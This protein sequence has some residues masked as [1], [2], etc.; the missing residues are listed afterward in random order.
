M[1]ADTI[2][3]FGLLDVSLNNN[4]AVTLIRQS[5]ID[6]STTRDNPFVC[7]QGTSTTNRCNQRERRSFEIIQVDQKQC[8]WRGQDV[9]W[10]L[11]RNLE[12][13]VIWLWSASTI[14]CQIVGHRWKNANQGFSM[15]AYLLPLYLVYKRETM[16]R[17]T[18]LT[19]VRQPTLHADVISKSKQT[20]KWNLLKL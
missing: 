9:S 15:A 16:T 12:R 20:K 2:R 17:A 10:T 19:V 6:S 13:G 11:S 4:V 7:V 18:S 3:N 8:S 5:Y 1:F 14:G